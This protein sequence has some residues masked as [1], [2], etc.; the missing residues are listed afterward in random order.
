VGEAEEEEEEEREEEEEKE[1]GEVAIVVLNLL[2]GRA[3]P[4]VLEVGHGRR[5]YGRR[6]RMLVRHVSFRHAFT[7][8]YRA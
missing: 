3:L 7:P 6:A 1:E 2:T 8:N 5:M 4:R